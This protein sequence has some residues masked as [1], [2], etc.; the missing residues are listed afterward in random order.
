MDYKKSSPWAKF[1]WRLELAARGIARAALRHAK[2]RPRLGTLAVYLVVLAC[3]AAGFAVTVRRGL[4]ERAASVAAITASGRD[5]APGPASTDSGAPPTGQGGAGPA[6]GD[7]T[8][9]SGSA[10]DAAVKVVGEG[11]D[12]TTGREGVPPVKPSDEPSKAHGPE[13]DRASSAVSPATMIRPAGGK[14]IEGFGWYR[15]PVYEDW[16]FHG[17]IDIGCPQGTPV[18]AALPGTVEKVY[19]D[20][21]LGRTVVLSHPGNIETV[22]G[23]CSAVS[24]SPGQKVDQGAVIARAGASGMA[25][26]PRLYFQVVDAGEPQD[27]QKYLGAGER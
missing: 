2:V 9:G 8:A 26:S 12:S 21:E 14:V 16:R 15:H 24:V 18:Y 19:D 3:L 23:H 13:E 7:K 25:S 11:A 22:Y 5:A 4:V 1:I 6:A 20:P 27:P 17:G 10:W